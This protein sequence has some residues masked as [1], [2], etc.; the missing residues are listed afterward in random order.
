MFTMS[1]FLQLWLTAGGVTSL[2]RGV[3]DLS[4]VKKHP[5]SRPDSVT[6]SAQI[7]YTPCWR[8]VVDILFISFL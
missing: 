2:G 1:V 3:W 6:H 7:G 4:P 8:F 5:A